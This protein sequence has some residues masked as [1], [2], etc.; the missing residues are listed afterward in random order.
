M[1][2]ANATR[3]PAL[4]R[5]E[6]ENRILDAGTC[7]AEGKRVHCVCRISIACKAHG[8]TCVGTHD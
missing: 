7:C 1:M 3:S 2:N 8:T 6:L 5:R 4:T